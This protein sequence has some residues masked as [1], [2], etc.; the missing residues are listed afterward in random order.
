MLLRLLEQERN[1]PWENPRPLFLPPASQAQLLDG[2][3]ICSGLPLIYLLE[4]LQFAPAG[5]VWGSVL[6]EVGSQD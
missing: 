5:R 4:G 3:F 6:G 2:H 1:P